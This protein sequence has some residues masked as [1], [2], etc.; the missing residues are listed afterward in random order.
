MM[1]LL[2]RTTRTQWPLVALTLEHFSMTIVALVQGQ[3]PAH[4]PARRAGAGVVPAVRPTEVERT[5]EEG[6][7]R[8][9]AKQQ[10]CS[11]AVWRPH[12]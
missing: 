12:S 2:L 6:A 7:N 1:Q 3:L 5:G 10:R 11:L 8:G 9:Q 4:P